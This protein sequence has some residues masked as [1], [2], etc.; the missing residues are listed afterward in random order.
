MQALDRLVGIIE[1]VSVSSEPPALSD[2]AQATGMSAS[3]C[4][5]LLG[6]LVVNGLLLRTPGGRGY[7]PGARLVRLAGDV[8]AATRESKAD[9]AL[10]E[11]VEMWDETF[12]LVRMNGSF[13]DV[14]IERRPQP[15]RRTMVTQLVWR[16]FATHAG[17]G[18]RAIMAHANA[19]DRDVALGSASFERFT[20]HTI[21]DIPSLLTELDATRERGYAISDQE[22]DIG[23]MTLATPVLLGDGEPIAAI[24]VIGIRERIRS[25]MKNG[26]VESMQMASKSISAK[27]LFEG[28]R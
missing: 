15:D 14:P 22:L 1:Y 25:A 7:V 19:A 20:E 11:L 9:L 13:A 3:T 10:S 18:T 16:P 6:E 28:A 26:L 23:V 12:Y 17:A 4:H 21:T 2:I 5:R 24:C 8:L 27:D